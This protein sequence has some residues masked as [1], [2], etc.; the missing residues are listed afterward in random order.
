MEEKKTV[1]DYLAQTMHIFGFSMLTLNVFCLIFGNSAREFSEIF[2]LG[3]QGVPVGIAFQ[4]L[5]ISTLITGTRFVFFT[6]I[7]IKKM[8]IGVRTILMLSFVIIITAAFIILF[9]WFPVNMWQ[10]WVMFFI[11]FGLSF[12]GSCFFV[13]VKEK[14]EN[15]RMKKALQQ[16][17]E[18]EEYKK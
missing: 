5:C 3:N 8:S 6:D 18:T 9:H 17:K 10:P 14:A 7:V 2:G 1:F 12:A 15:E 4:F 16:L 13:T 11:C